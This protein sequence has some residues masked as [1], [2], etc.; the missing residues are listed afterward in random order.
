MKRFDNPREFRYSKYVLFDGGVP[1]RD[2]LSSPAAR[3]SGH[4]RLIGGA[5]AAAPLLSA[6]GSGKAAVAESGAAAPS[7]V[8]YGRESVS[9]YQAA[10]SSWVTNAGDPLRTFYDGIVKQYGT[11]N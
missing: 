8:K 1:W 6:C 7:T 4:P 11:G 9:D 5:I 3:C 10:L 2:R